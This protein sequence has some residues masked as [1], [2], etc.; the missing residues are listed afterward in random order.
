MPVICTVDFDGFDELHVGMGIPSVPFARDSMAHAIDRCS[1][2]LPIKD[3]V[4]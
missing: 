4:N 2:S 3:T 1:I